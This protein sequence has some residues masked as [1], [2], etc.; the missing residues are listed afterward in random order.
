M[1]RRAALAL[2]LVSLLLPGNLLA[3]VLQ[4]A[5]AGCES[6]SCGCAA[7]PADESSPAWAEVCCC[8]TQPMPAPGERP[9]QPLQQAQGGA[10]PELD[11]LQPGTM[12]PFV[13]VRADQPAVRMALAGFGPPGTLFLRYHSLRL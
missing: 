13:P 10:T 11:A 4:D 1:L 2:A 5:G 3:G 8:A 6:Q 12:L 9:N 7:P